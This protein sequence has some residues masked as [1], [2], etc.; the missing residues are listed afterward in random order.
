MIRFLPLFLSLILISACTIEEMDVATVPNTLPVQTET[1]LATKII[2]P[3]QTLPAAKI[4]ISTNAPV[5][6]AIST[7]TTT[8]ISTRCD[9]V[10]KNTDDETS[11]AP[12]KLA[13]IKNND[14]W[15]WD[16]QSAT[17]W[18]LTDSHDI[19]QM[20]LSPD[21]QFIAFT[22]GPN[23]NPLTL[24]AFEPVPSYHITDLWIMLIG[25]KMGIEFLT[26]I[27]TSIKLSESRIIPYLPLFQ[28]FYP[29]YVS[30]LAFL[31]IF[32]RYDWKS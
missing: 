29:V 30:T 32:Q 20:K 2:V 27:V 24:M 21:Y 31:G 10:E 18:P 11:E 9:Q 26:L 13:Y 15:M 5:P 7:A 23:N 16:Q 19:S 8:E 22:R 28:I 17:T 3:T 25:A 1:P 6:T 14:I 12:L 4:T